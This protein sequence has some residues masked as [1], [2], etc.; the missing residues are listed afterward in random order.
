MQFKLVHRGSREAVDSVVTSDNRS[1]AQFFQ[2]KKRLP[3]ETFDKLYEVVEQN[4]RD[5][6]TRF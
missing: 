2:L 5:R 3:L 4:D 1:A 6:P